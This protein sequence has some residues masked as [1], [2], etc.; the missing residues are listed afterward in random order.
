MFLLRFPSRLSLRSALHTCF[1]PLPH[2]RT[3]LHGLLDLL[4]ASVSRSSLS[5]LFFRQ[6]WNP[7]M[8]VLTVVQAQDLGRQFGSRLALI[9]FV[10]TVC[11]PSCR[12]PL[13]TIVLTSLSVLV[14]ITVHKFHDQEQHRAQ[15]TLEENRVS[16]TIRIWWDS[17]SAL[18]FRHCSR[19]SEAKTNLE[20]PFSLLS[21]ML[22]HSKYQTY[23]L[24]RNQQTFPGSVV[25]PFW[26]YEDTGFWPV[27][28]FVLVI[29]SIAGLRWKQTLPLRIFQTDSLK[30]QREGETA[31]S[32]HRN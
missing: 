2:L 1:S 21:C 25:S 11:S 19:K 15:Q 20:E 30:K 28:L 31:R 10:F 5:G 32:V 16:Y 6:S 26:S 22:A 29:I 9:H 14:E 13:V 4:Q 3:S 24:Y 23:T 7:S 18:L 17:R 27:S 12:K 8:Q